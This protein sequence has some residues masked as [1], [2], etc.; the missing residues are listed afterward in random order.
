MAAAS[1]V[2]VPASHLDVARD[3][4]PATQAANAAMTA[5]LP[6]ADARDFEAAKRGLMAHGARGRDQ[7]RER[8]CL[9]SLGEYAFLAGES[10]TPTTVNPSLWRMARLNMSNGLFQVTDRIYQV[11]GFD[12][13]E[14][15]DHRGRH[16]AHRHRPAGLPGLVARGAAAVPY[17]TAAAA[18]HRGDLHP[19]PCRSLRRRAGVIDEGDVEAGRVA[20]IA[21]DGFMEAIGPG[22]RA[23]RPAMASARAVPVRRPAAAR[24]RGPGRCRARQG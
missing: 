12:I 15:D 5:G 16:G 19:Q 6:F 3:A 13:S 22:E 7:D 4:D 18:G 10:S 2:P 21:P 14:H 9:W 11:R 8:P 23:G 20:M 24:A 17:R 1:A